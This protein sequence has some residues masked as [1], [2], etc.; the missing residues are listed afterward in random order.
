M[1]A[2][3]G[4]TQQRDIG[5]GIVGNIIVQQ[6]KILRQGAWPVLCILDDIIYLNL[7]WHDIQVIA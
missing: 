5:R 1:F 2:Q 3:E 7:E 6:G 4:K